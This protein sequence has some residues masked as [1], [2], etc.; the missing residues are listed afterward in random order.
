MNNTKNKFY[1]QI[2]SRKELD[3]VFDNAQKIE[4]E[5]LKDYEEFDEMIAKMLGFIISTYHTTKE[6][7]YLEDF[8]LKG[9]SCVP[10]GPRLAIL[11]DAKIFKK[12]ILEEHRPN[13]NALMRTLI[14]NIENELI[15]NYME[16]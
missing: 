11:A 14:K 10:F 15:I 8:V 2:E 4:K 7:Q 13:F 6:F 3:E 9:W 16:D 12:Y 5:I 1:C